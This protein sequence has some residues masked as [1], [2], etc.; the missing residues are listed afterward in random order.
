MIR[1]FGNPFATMHP[2]GAQ[3]QLL[4]VRGAVFS[5]ADA[6]ARLCSGEL[7]FPL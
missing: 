3:V 5:R 7:D 1:P 2:S 6:I 4:V